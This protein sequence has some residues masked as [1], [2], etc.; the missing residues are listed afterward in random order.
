MVR[1]KK[2]FPA[3]LPL[4]L[5]AATALFISACNLTS[6]PQEPIDTT[7][8][9]T[10]TVLPTRTSSAPTPVTVTALPVIPTQ[11]PQGSTPVVILPPTSL[12]FPT[13]TPLPIS[14]FILSPIPGSVVAGNVQVL[15]AAVHPQFLQYQLEYGPDP[16]PGNLWYPAS[17]VVQ[18]PV[19]SGILGIWNTTVIQDSVYQ[20]RLRVTLRDGT[21]LI[22]VANSIR[23]QNRVPTPI[24]TATTIPRPIAAFTQDRVIG[25]APLVVRFFNQS[26]GSVSSHSWSFGDGG[27]SPEVNPVHTFRNPG[28]YTVQ[29]TVAGPGGSSNVSRQ[30]NVQSAVPPVAGFTQDVTSGSSP[31]TVRFTDQSTGAVTTRAW[32]FGDGQTSA[33]LNPAHTFTAVGTYNVIL[34]VSGPGGSSSVTRQITVQNPTIPAPIAALVASQTTGNAPLTVQFDASDS[35]GQIDSYN[36]DF[37]DGQLGTGR[38]VTHTFTAAGE[39]QVRLLVVGPG[40]QSAAQAAITAVRPP[41]APVASFTAN[42][43]SGDIPLTVQFDAAGSTGPIDSYAW[44]FGDGQSGSGVSPS[45]TFTAPGTYTVELTV[46]GPGG[47]SSTSVAVSATEPVTPPAAAFEITALGA[48]A[49]LEVEFINQT[50]GE[51]LTFAWDFGDGQTSAERAPRHTFINPGTYTVTLTAEGLGGTDTAQQTFEVSP[52]PEV[53]AAFTVNPPGGEAPLSVQLEAVQAANLVAYAW[54]FSDGGTAAGPS[55]SYTFANPGSYTVTLT[56]TS[57]DGRSASA[58]QTVAVTA[59]APPPGPGIVLQTPILPD[60]ESPTVQAHLRAIYERGLAQGRR[61]SVFARAGDDQ[62]VQPGYL[63]PFADP[64]LTLSDAAFQAVVD[65][66]NQLDVGGGRSSF[67]YVG[68]AARAGWRAEDLLDPAR[69]DVVVCSPGETPLGCE[70]RMLQPGV[71][72]VSVGLNN[73]FDGDL[74]AFRAALDTSIQTLLDSGVIPV[75]ST[76]QPDPRDPAA[77]DAVNTAIIETAQGVAGRNN[78]TVPIYNL[79]RRYNDLPSSGLAGDGTTPTVAPAGPGDLSPE[80][81]NGFGINARNRDILTILDLLRSRIYPDAQ[82]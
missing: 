61:A 48:Y 72:L 63:T 22:T 19:V 1:S 30:I 77:T 68:A 16:N 79:W 78:T 36:W 5:A 62:A 6:T 13:S 17:G 39:Y 24:P 28:V 65:W 50:S 23:I 81:V 70:I 40:G 55:A 29:L 8:V 67:D 35:S 38:I 31:L 57:A 9:P 82:P 18:M 37:G 25:Q 21:N 11:G 53:T 51:N 33:E 58:D 2:P 4:L 41:D 45:H 12:P 42:P 76:I 46:S 44:N 66:H 7:D 71:A 49:P 15:G 32:N 34:T 73:V 14:I 3:V 60:L 26:T 52:A 27:S 20:L 43:T 74:T 69:A 64:G 47:T 75:V 54:A 56:V 80:S 59:P 10:T